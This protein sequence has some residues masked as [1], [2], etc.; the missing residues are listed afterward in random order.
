M[1]MSKVAKMEQAYE[2]KKYTLRSCLLPKATDFS[3]VIGYNKLKIEAESK[4]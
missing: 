2:K 3:G 4:N 1:G